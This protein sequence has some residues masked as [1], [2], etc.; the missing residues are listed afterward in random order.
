MIE[1]TDEM[2]RNAYTD[3]RIWADRHGHA[4]PD[5]RLVDVVIHAVIAVVERDYDV[6]R[7]TSHVWP[8]RVWPP[9]RGA[10]HP[11]YCVSCSDGHAKGDGCI[12]C[13]QTGYDQSPWPDCGQC[14]FARRVSSA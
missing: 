9:N 2:R 13:R 11:H 6:L 1:P 7:R 12:N 3:A 4:Q 10:L 14:R 5:D 8:A